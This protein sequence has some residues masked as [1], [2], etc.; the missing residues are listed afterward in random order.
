MAQLDLG[1]RTVVLGADVQRAFEAIAK[2]GPYDLIFADPPYADVPSGR[3]ASTIDRLLAETEVV[4]Q[5]SWLVIEHA[6]RDAAPVL[7]TAEHLRSRAY[8]DTEL[9]FYA[10]RPKPAPPGPDKGTGQDFRV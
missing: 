8:G 4:T 7:E 6:A 3:L 10:P 9:S 2:L 5:D 1:D